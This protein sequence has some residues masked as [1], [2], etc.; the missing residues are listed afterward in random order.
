MSWEI[1]GH[2]D[3]DFSVIDEEGPSVD[4]ELAKKIE[5]VFVES[6]GYNI[7]LKKIMKAY[8]HPANLLNLKLPNINPEIESSQKYQSN[9]SFVMTNKK[10]LY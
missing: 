7:K 10:S 3:D 6:S 5:N 1:L 9:N 8:K 2:V 4:L